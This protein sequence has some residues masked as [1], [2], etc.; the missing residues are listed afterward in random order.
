VDRTFLGQFLAAG[1]L[2]ETE[3]LAC[4]R[5]VDPAD[6]EGNEGKVAAA[7]KA[8]WRRDAPPRA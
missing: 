8:S 6:T 1:A 5:L 3:G 2:D 4:R 7:G